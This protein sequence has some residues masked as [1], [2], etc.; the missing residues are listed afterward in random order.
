VTARDGA[1]V[2]LALALAACGSSGNAPAPGDGG[3]TAASEAGDTAASEAGDAVAPDAGDATGADG[4]DV[5]ADA[6]AQD[7]AAASTE[8]CNGFV[9][10]SPPTAG[11]PNPASYAANA[12]GTVTETVSGLTWEGTVDGMSYT[13]EDAAAH[14]AAKGGSWRLPTRLE[15]ASLVDFTIA[16]PGPTINAIFADTPPVVF[17]TQ[18]LYHN[19]AGD[20]W[21]VGFDVGYSDY[22]VR[23]NPDPVRCVLPPAP[24]CLPKRYVVPQ[25]AVGVIQDLTTGLTWQRTL[26]G[27]QYTWDDAKAYCAGMGAGWRVPSLTELQTIVDDVTEYPAIDP[28]VFPDTPHDDFWTSTPDPSG[29]GAA[30]YVDFFYGATDLDVPTRVFYVRCV[31]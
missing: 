12:D 5:R 20:A 1:L 29:I 14:C 22:G 13:Q 17:W 4:A 30:W 2:V 21:S 16:S 18:T 27:K 10:P 11:L 3:D 7:G 8:V 23:N 31:R 19:N 9:M 26:D 15:L 24:V 25:T 6:D 28:V